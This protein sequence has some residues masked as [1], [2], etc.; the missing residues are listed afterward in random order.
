MV[1]T[2]LSGR[3]RERKWLQVISKKKWTENRREVGTNRDSVL[4]LWFWV[5]WGIYSQEIYCG[6]LI[7]CTYSLQCAGCTVITHHCCDCVLIIF[8]T[9]GGNAKAGTELATV[10][11]RTGSECSLPS[12]GTGLGHLCQPGL[13]EGGLAA[14]GSGWLCGSSSGFPVSWYLS[15]SDTYC[16]HFPP[17]RCVLTAVGRHTAAVNL[18]AA[19]SISW[20]CLAGPKESSECM[21]MKAAMLAWPTSSN[22]TYTEVHTVPD[23]STH[24]PRPEDMTRL[25]N[26]LCMALVSSVI[27][28][29]LQIP[30][31]P[32]RDLSREQKN[33][34]IKAQAAPGLE[35]P[36]A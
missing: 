10:P 23:R 19:L 35:F 36:S 16:L 9:M 18:T 5:T 33:T 6:H 25:V 30:W 4:P 7:I 29:S 15:S 2:A 8:G 32:K 1:L 13:R 28:L 20:R 14:E 21:N 31:S 24:L 12:S 22:S 27:L 34:E 11:R 26:G 17:S 3:D